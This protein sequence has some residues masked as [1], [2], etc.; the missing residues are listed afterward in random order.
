MTWFDYAACRDARTLDFFDNF[1]EAD[2]EQ[3]MEIVE[4]CKG[5]PVRV[6]C[7]E[8]AETFPNTYGLWGGF[9]YKN[10]KKKD[11]LKIAKTKSDLFATN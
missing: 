10:G 6:E 11:P 5:C 3:R 1:E 9:Y 7:E 4:M 8:Y 2:Q